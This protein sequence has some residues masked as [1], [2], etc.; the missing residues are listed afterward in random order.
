MTSNKFQ[1]TQEQDKSINKNREIK[2]INKKIDEMIE[3]T[4]SS[5]EFKPRSNKIEPQSIPYLTQQ[6]K[7]NLKIDF[8]V[9]TIPK[10]LTFDTYSDNILK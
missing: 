1:P 5:I 8:L 4:P 10:N 9:T 7:F 3:K 2:E 6:E